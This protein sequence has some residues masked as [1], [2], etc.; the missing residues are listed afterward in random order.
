MKNIWSSQQNKILV[1]KILKHN[2]KQLVWPYFRTQCS[3]YILIKFFT[4]E[5]IET[6]APTFLS[7]NNLYVATVYCAEQV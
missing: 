2:M 3:I 6:H 1:N 7:Y 5:T 4:Y